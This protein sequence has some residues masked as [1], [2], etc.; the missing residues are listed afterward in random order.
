MSLPSELIDLDELIQNFE[1]YMMRVGKRRACERL[2]E[3]G[4][5]SDIFDTR[6]ENVLELIT[7]FCGGLYVA[8]F[9]QSLRA[10]LLAFGSPITPDF[11]STFGVFVSQIISR[12]LDPHVPLLTIRRD[13]QKLADQYRIKVNKEDIVSL[14]HAQF[15]ESIYLSEV[16]W[17]ILNKIGVLDHPDFPRMFVECLKRVGNGLSVEKTIIATRPLFYLKLADKKVFEEACRGLSN[18]FDGLLGFSISAAYSMISYMLQRGVAIPSIS[19]LL[20]ALTMDSSEMLLLY[21]KACNGDESLIYLILNKVITVYYR[22]PIFK[23]IDG[24]L[25][26]RIKAKNAIELLLHAPYTTASIQN[27]RQTFKFILEVSEKLSEEEGFERQIFNLLTK[28][29]FE[30]RPAIIRRFL[31]LDDSRRLIAELIIKLPSKLILVALNR[32]IATY[33]PTIRHIGHSSDDLCSELKKTLNAVLPDWRETLDVRTI[34][35][36]GLK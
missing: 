21:E 1:E 4:G 17:Y 14:N 6:I 24:I 25:S 35:Y 29:A 19:A 30:A 34:K 33:A 2:V 31:E 27:I 15:H 23:I 36:L 32:L 13:F 3:L 11:I 16:F 22:G 9:K 12:V 20:A 18:N 28:M 26:G 8:K 10:R 5:V 7:K